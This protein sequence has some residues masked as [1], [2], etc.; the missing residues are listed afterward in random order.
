[1]IDYKDINGLE[2]EVSS[3][4]NALCPQCGRRWLGGVKNPLLVEKYITLQNIKDWLSV[5]FIKQLNNIEMCGNYG[6]AMTNP[7]LVP[8]LQYIKSI[9]PLIGFYMNTNASGRDAEFWK[10]L[11]E[12]FKENGTLVFS[13]D[14]LEDTNWIYR[15]GTKW[16]MIMTAMKS[17]ISTGANAR[18]EFLVFRHNQHQIEEARALSKE[19]GFEMFSPKRAMGFVEENNQYN[20]HVRGTKGEYQYTIK[21]PIDVETKNLDPSQDNRNLGKGEYYIN[22]E[23]N[24]DLNM[25]YIKDIKS[26]LETESQDIAFFPMSRYLESSTLS[27]RDKK[28]GKA[29]IQCKAIDKKHLFI[30]SKGYVFPCCWTASMYE[31]PDSDLSLPLKNFVNNYGKEKISLHHTA[32]K[33][34]V[35]GDMY[36]NKW[37]ESFKDRDF[38]NKRLKVC[39]MFCGVKT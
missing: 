33:D 15:K 21:P 8:I 34:I 30:N 4:C 39:S 19:L 5:D 23:E 9:N 24:P 36:T 7:D 29:N 35:D 13:V 12:V 22:S 31:Q 38:R 25:G 16:D 18:W 27:S 32:L 1:M 14:G 20:M 2:I 3:L 17:Y 6:D 28:L 37:I 11:G 10:D 26:Q